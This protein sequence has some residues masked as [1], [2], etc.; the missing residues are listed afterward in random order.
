[1]NIQLPYNWKPRKYQFPLWRYFRTKK[2]RARALAIWHRRAGKDLFAVNLCATL[3][4]ERVGLYWHLLPTYQ[5]GRKIVWN[6]MTRDGTKFLDAFPK[7]LVK[8]K[9]ETEMR[10][11]LKNGSIYQVIGT[12]NVDVLVGTNPIFCVFSEYSIQDPRAWDYIRPILAENG[13]GALFIYTPRGRNHGYSLKQIAERNDNWYP[14]ILPADKTGAISEE[15]IQ[16]ERDSGMSEEMIQQEYYCSFDAPLNGAYYAEQFKYLEEND[17]ITK[18]PWEPNLP[19]DTYWDLG[20]TDAT[21]IWFVQTFRGEHRVID[22]YVATGEGLTY[23]A[24]K[25][26]EK[27]YAYG[28]HYAPWDIKISEIGTG[29]TRYETARQVG[30]KFKVVSKHKREDGIDAVRNMLPKCWFDE[31]KCEQ[32]IN[33]LRSYHKEWDDKL[34]IFSSSPCH[35]WSSHGADAFRTFA[36]GHRSRTYTKQKLPT[37][38][39]DSYSYL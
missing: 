31:E 27:P 3:A 5:Q 13:G 28:K 7:E 18:V 17:R 8:S 9:N 38:V 23:H 22:Y 29:E 2:E 33:A 16:D 39:Q 21:A 37:R 36:M 20:K 4:F 6:G 15:V 30:L 12:D 24:K 35:D 32:G 19:V 1:M 11:T 10:L 25:L 14:S 26:E 34:K